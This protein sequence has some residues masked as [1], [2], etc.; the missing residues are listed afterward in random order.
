MAEHSIIA[1]PPRQIVIESVVAC[2][3]RCPSCYIG[4]GMVT[5]KNQLMP[6][7]LFSRLAD[8]IESYARHVYLHLW[9]EPTLHPR[10]GEMI[11]RVR[12]FATVDLSTHGL[13]DRK[14]VV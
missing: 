12:K 1:D 6:W 2:N 10:I 11:C 8:E 4:A 7:E 3:L 5:R 14:S 13:L 9:G